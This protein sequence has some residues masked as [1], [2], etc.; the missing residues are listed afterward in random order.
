MNVLVYKIQSVAAKSSAWFVIFFKSQFAIY[1]VLFT[2]QYVSVLRNKNMESDQT[3]RSQSFLSFH[4]THKFTFRE[5]VRLNFNCS[6]PSAL[7][8]SI[9]LPKKNFLDSNRRNYIRRLAS[10][11]GILYLFTTHFIKS[12]WRVKI[13]IYSVRH[14][15]RECKRIL[16]VQ[17]D[18]R[19][20]TELDYNLR[21]ILGCR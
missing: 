19:T 13:S 14:S 16:W 7:S 20:K 12:H 8:Y 3:R 10:I 17:M 21:K 15:I 11:D 9:Y 18:L 2:C 5:I 4:V 6:I 1:F